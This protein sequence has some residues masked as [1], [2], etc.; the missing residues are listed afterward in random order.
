MKKILSLLL[1][2]VLA[3][4]V[5]A[6]CG[7]KTN[8]NLE[9][10]GE[11]LDALYKNES[12]KTTVNY[13]I[14]ANVV[15]NGVTYPVTWTVDVTEGVT[16]V[17]S[18]TAGFKTVEV[19]RGDADLKYTLTATLTDG[20]DS[21]TKSYERV[22]P[23][24]VPQSAIVEAAYQ[25]AAG[26]VMEGT[27]TLT[28]VITKI[29]T[30]YSDS[31]KN[32]T[33]TIVVDGLSDK[34]IM[35]YRLKGD[36]AA[37]LKIGDTITVEGTIKN[38][39]GTIE[40]DAG[41]QIKAYTAWVADAAGKIE[42][43]KTALTLNTNIAINTVINLP[44]AG[45]T[46]TDV[47]ITWTAD[48]TAVSGGYTVTLGDEA[49]TVKLVATIACEGATAATKE[50]TLNIA[51][52]P[53]YVISKVDAPVVDTWYYFY[54]VQETLGQTY[55]FNGANDGY[56]VGTTDD[57]NS[58]VKVKLA[59]RAGTTDEYDI[60]FDDNG[61]TKYLVTYLS[62][63]YV[64]GKVDT[65]PGEVGYKYNTYI[66]GM[67]ITLNDT[68]YYLG[69]FSYN[70]QDNTNIRASKISFVLDDNNQL[71]N[72]TNYVCH[73][74]EMVD[75]ASVSAADKIAAEKAV[76]NVESVITEAGNITLPAIGTTYSDVAITWAVTANGAATLNG[77]V[78]AVTIPAADT[79]VT[80]TATIT[81]GEVSDTKVFTLTVKAPALEP[82]TIAEVLAA[83]NNALDFWVEGVVIATNAKSFLVKDSTG[84]ILVYLNAN[85]TFAVGDKVSIKGKTSEY[86]D[87]WQFTNT[88]IVV[89]KIGTESFTQPTPTVL[90]G[91]AVDAVTTPVAPTYV[92]VTGTLAVSGN[93]LNLTVEGATRQGSLKYLAEPLLST[94]NALDGKKIEV[95]GYAIGVS[96]T[97]GKYLDI[98]VTSVTEVVISDP[99]EKIA[100]E[101]NAL[102]IQTNF[103]ADGTLTLPATGSSYSDVAIT[104]TVN[105][106]AA[107]GS[108]TIT[109]TA[110][111]QT[112]TVVATLTCGTES[113][114]KTFTVTVKAPTLE[115]DT[116]AE[117]LAAQNNTT[118]FWVEGVVIGV[119]TKS[120]LVKD[121][122]GAML[123]Y[124]NAAP[125]VAVGDKVSVKGCTSAYNDTWQFANVSGGTQLTISS[126]G[127]E[128][129]FTQPTP[130]VL[131]GAAVDAVTAPVAPTYVKVTG[132][133]VKSGN[134]VNIVVDGATKQGS[135]NYLSTDLTNIATA[136]NGKLVEVV[137]YT[138]GIS[139]GKYVNIMT[140]SITE[141]VA[142]DAQKAAI[143]KNA[144]TIQTNFTAD[145][146]LTLP[147]AGTA[148]SDVAI[149]WTVNGTAAT[150]SYTIT[151]TAEAQTLTVIAT[152]ACGTATPATKEF[153][154]TVAAPSQGPAEE[155]VLS[156]TN[157]KNGTVVY[158]TGAVS[159]GKPGATTDK[160]NAATVYTEDAG[161]GKVYIY[162]MVSGAKK[163]LTMTGN[164][165]TAF[166]LSDTAS[167][168]WIVTAT[169]IQSGETLSE[170][171]IYSYNNSDFRA[172]TGNNYS[173]SNSN[174][175]V[176]LAKLETK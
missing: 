20:E 109:Q 38:Y 161:D 33:V 153:T 92:K 159:S 88:G 112:L 138:T 57:V 36:N 24:K 10:A 158:W 125:N 167:Y 47:V 61:T 113:D 149:T 101:K 94:V 86:N 155:F 141:A 35:C 19:V 66:G 131:D 78:L 173:P 44:A 136:L 106:T 160:A 126:L 32:I 148:Y 15:Y 37:D 67:Q 162:V 28:G 77:N 71:K 104:W 130:T 56:Y 4:G 128:S 152:L 150:G 115:P 175:T 3:V 76:L 114:T 134:Y 12:P 151:Q 170:R 53:S 39:N 83:E 165:T 22:V 166:A 30:A 116:V 176:G 97:G 90:D 72:G 17:D 27:Q 87:T 157:S 140:T 111:A 14:V 135:P 74:G 25:L 147:A 1:V 80:L 29:D 21:I 122:T 54:V 117:V 93:Y 48:G 174:Q 23:A 144:L 46:Y 9:A 110:E 85:P 132:V 139:S 172:Y 52:K 156:A 40:F 34:P 103:T 171:Y 137:G 82:D 127:T 95:V 102:T 79:T 8:E 65:A 124:L 64:N 84:A 169:S 58:A 11:Y 100:A 60:V 133:L 163:Y 120:F 96:G 108:Y 154:V 119:N 142:T 59:L 45:T 143:E 98:M 16:I 31:Y 75:I 146:T 43:E 50:F 68:V 6:S 51:K 99:A 73:F 42:I 168:K 145:G 121:A 69:T 18:A 164:T 91:A 7:P 81:S 62:G 63:T 118:E 49:R 5:I 13:D 129:G 41:C 26:D 89:E 70:G 2:L 105:G 55:Y 123:V 107:T